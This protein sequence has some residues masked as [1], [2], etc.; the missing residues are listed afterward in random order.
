MDYLYFVLM[1]LVLVAAFVFLM[2]I[3]RKAKNKYKADA[4]ELLENSDPE[5][6]HVKD[7]VRGLRL[8]SGRI[9]KDKEAQELV[10]RLL[11]KHGHVFG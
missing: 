10:R 2:R 3:D 5:P 1:I 9:R 8:Y 6:K 11:D 4:Y 7:T